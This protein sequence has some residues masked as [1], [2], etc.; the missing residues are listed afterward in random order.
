MPAEVMT[1]E[2]IGCRP[3]HYKVLFSSER[4][5]GLAR[6]GFTDGETGWPVEA[7][8]DAPLEPA[9]EYFWNVRAWTDGVNGPASSTRI[10]FTG[11]LC[12]SSA[13]LAPPELLTPESGTTIDSLIA[14]LHYQP[15]GSSPCVPEGYFIDLQTDPDFGGTTLLAEYGIPGTYVFTEE[16]EDCRTY[17]WR[18]AA[19]QGGERGPFSEVGTFHVSVSP[20][21]VISLAPDL[22]EGIT[23]LNICSPEDLIGPELVYPPNNSYV[24][25]SVTE[26]PLDYD[27]FQWQQL[28]CL[29]DEYRIE[30]STYRDFVNYRGGFADATA[31]SWPSADDPY[32]QVPLEKA[33]RYYWRVYAVADG[34]PGPT[35]SSWYFFTGP[36]C[37]L[38]A[39][40]LAPRL[41]TPFDGTVINERHGELHWAAAHDTCLPDGYLIDLQVEPDFSGTNLLGEYAWPGTYLITDELSN[42]TTY[43]WRVAAMEDGGHGPFSDVRSFHIDESGNC[44]LQFGNIPQLEAL[45]DLACYAGPNPGAYEILGYLLE[46]E[47]ATIVAQNLAETWWIIQNPDG[48]DTCYV[49]KAGTEGGEEVEDIP[50]WNDPAIEPDVPEPESLTCSRDLNKQ[51]C[52]KAGGVW[53]MPPEGGFYCKCD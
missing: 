16:L 10:F 6:L 13:D 28:D 20:T 32:P 7:G 12:S 23:E 42:C 37:E 25:S 14:E 11:P 36:E 33:S 47:T 45:R 5:F 17:Y 38:T 26:F 44:Q 22:P 24:R 41:V 15:G 34:V 30:I 48:F 51:D 9:T 2:D 46:G 29:P 27:F 4:D 31:A 40:L 49:S 52:R 19:H 50:R 8:A 3:E 1:W 18:V 39:D 53:T 43:Y 35:S 21:C